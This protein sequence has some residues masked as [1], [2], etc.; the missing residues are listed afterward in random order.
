MSLVR[1]IRSADKLF[2]YRLPGDD[3]VYCDSLQG[4]GPGLGCPDVV[5]RWPVDAR[6]WRDSLCDLLSMPDSYN[7]GD[8]LCICYQDFAVRAEGREGWTEIFFSLGDSR[9]FIRSPGHTSVMGYFDRVDDRM[10]ALVREI[11]PADMVL[12]SNGLIG[13][14][15]ATLAND[16]PNRD[17]PFA[18]DVAPVPL[19]TPLPPCPDSLGRSCEGDSV[20]LRLRIGAEGSVRVA[21][22]V[23]G[24]STLAN[25]A[26]AAARRWDFYP[27]MRGKHPVAAWIQQWVRFVP[28]R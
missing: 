13:G 17:A 8:K 2:A 25:L 9:I 4:S 18:Y 7:G 12:G 16:F 26:A 24:D 21:E 5:R 20:R 10:R 23:A 3:P 22:A 14:P 28:R 19:E 27:A 6:G 11:L 1:R 15:V